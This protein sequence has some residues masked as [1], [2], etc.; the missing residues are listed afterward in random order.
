MGDLLEDRLW[1]G[2]PTDD[3]EWEYEWSYVGVHGK[4]SNQTTNSHTN[5]NTPT[6]L[7][8]VI[9]LNTQHHPWLDQCPPWRCTNGNGEWDM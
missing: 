1:M 5:T 7:M 3:G 9:H 2:E 6:R 8:F 4:A